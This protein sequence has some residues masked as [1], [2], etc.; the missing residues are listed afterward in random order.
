LDKEDYAISKKINSA[1]TKKVVVEEKI[2]VVVDVDG[3]EEVDVDGNEKGDGEQLSSATAASD[4]VGDTSLYVTKKDG[5]R[6]PLDKDKVRELWMPMCGLEMSHHYCDSES[7]HA[8]GEF[9]G[10]VGNIEINACMKSARGF[11]PFPRECMIFN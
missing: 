4:P 3:K 1:E 11:I 2:D 5:S 6:E 7:N 10:C 8:L 9:G